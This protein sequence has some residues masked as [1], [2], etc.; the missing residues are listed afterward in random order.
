MIKERILDRNTEGVLTNRLKELER[1]EYK[2]NSEL[3]DDSKIH[4]Q[5]DAEQRKLEKLHRKCAVMREKLLNPTY[6]PDYQTKR[7]FIEFLGITA[8]IWE[9]GHNPKFRIEVNP[10]EIVSSRRWT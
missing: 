6:E 3:L 9:K 2:Y 1:L 8:T 4:Q 7:D 10:P 5:W